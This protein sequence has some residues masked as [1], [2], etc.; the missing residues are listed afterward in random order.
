M[1][2]TWNK[3]LIKKTYHTKGLHDNLLT[4]NLLQ[5]TET[6]KRSNANALSCN[7]I[8]C[9][10]NTESTERLKTKNRS[11]I[12]KSETVVRGNGFNITYP[13]KEAGSPKT[14]AKRRTRANP[15]AP[16]MLNCSGVL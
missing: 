8:R 12:R 16:L 1:K 15:R 5:G 6:R 7:K 10:Q 4:G 3:R 14:E 9:W 11:V 2:R 13:S